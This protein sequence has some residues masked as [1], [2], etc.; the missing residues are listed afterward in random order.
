MASNVF[1]QFDASPAKGGNVFDQFDEGSKRKTPKQMKIGAAGFPEAFKS[2]FEAAGPVE[3]KLAAAGSFARQLYEGG[4]QMIGMEDKPAIQATRIMQ[5]EEPG[6][7]IAGGV[8]TMVPLSM[9]PGAGSVAAQGAM[10]AGIGALQPTQEGE[11]RLKNAALGGALGA[12]STL[13][14]KGVGALAKPFLT[15]AQQAAQDIASQ[16]SARTQTIKESQAIGLKLPPSVTGGKA[17]AKGLESV[18]GKAATAQEASIQNQQVINAVARQEAGLPPNVPITQQALAEA[19]QAMAKPYKEI[20]AISPRAASALEKLQEARLDAKDAWKKYGGP[21]GGPAERKAALAADNKV[22]VLERLIDKEAKAVGREDL[23]PALRQARI[24]IAKNHDVEAAL[25]LGDGNVEASVIGRILDRRGEKAVTGGLRIIGKFQQAF[26]KFA[27]ERPTGES[28]PGVGYLKYPLA[29]G[30]GAEGY[31][32][33]E[34]HGIGPYGTAAGLLALAGGPARSIALSRLMQTAPE[35]AP[36][37]A[38]RLTGA[39]TGPLAQRLIPLS[40]VATQA[41]GAGQ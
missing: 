16:M 38:A 28:A 37:M 13:A 33:G 39:A 21:M 7:A 27:R 8:A 20:A 18:A 6:A 2:V 14:L 34:K 11:S 4:K 41:Q 9:I 10:G 26:P 25:N 19:R 17:V 3:R 22:A 36:G 24:N 35:Y 30:L 32:F 12:G 15:K 1:D 40:A 5:Q 23:L 29:L 31:N